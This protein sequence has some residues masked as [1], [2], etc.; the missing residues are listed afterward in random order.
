MQGPAHT[1]IVQDAFEFPG[2]GI[3]HIGAELCTK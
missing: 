3:F 2:S 1:E